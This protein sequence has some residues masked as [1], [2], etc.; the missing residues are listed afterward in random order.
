MQENRSFDNYFGVYPGADNL[1]SNNLLVPS[2]RS[3]N[4]LPDGKC[5]YP[6]L[7]HADL[8]IGGPHNIQGSV[9]DINDGAMNGFATTQQ[10]SYKQNCSSVLNPACA[11][12]TGPEDAMSYH[13]Q[14]DL[15]NY[16]SYAQHY[17]LQ[18]HMFEP[19]PAWS[20][21]AHLKLV[22][23]WSASC[24]SASPMSCA[25]DL[26]T[27]LAPGASFAHPHKKYSWTD[28]TYLLHKANVSWRYYVQSGGQPDCED[29]GQLTCSSV[30]QNSF[31]PGIWN[32]LP[33]FEDVKSDH[34]LGNIQPLT[35][36]TAAARTGTLPSVSWIVPASQNS[37]HPGSKIS[38]GVA[39][40]T[41]LVNQIMKSP[42][43]SSTAL[44]ITWDDW[45][46]F[47]DNVPPAIVGG[48]Q[49]GLRVPGLVISPFAKSNY[50]DHTVY[51]FDSYL[52][53]IEDD[54]LNAQRLNPATDG[55]PDGRAITYEDQAGLGNL[56]NDFD[57]SAR[58]PTPPLVLSPHPKSTLR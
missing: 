15:P 6:F 46:G 9:K 36:F 5:S 55:R 13:S 19:I 44:F 43:W 39:F 35:K 17:V 42:D 29:A 48:T 2:A 28:L 41:S 56:I 49:T 3:C 38:S 24:K 23:G 18:D 14:S 16:W 10:N 47:Y 27:S 8:Q 30:K 31:T 57:F 45:G 25:T 58:S 22:S 52:R 51:T 20:L 33:S 32:P 53:F 50:V 34:Q 26:Q 12:I 11:S 21:P 1:L 7:D 4:P 54:F 40:T 37:E